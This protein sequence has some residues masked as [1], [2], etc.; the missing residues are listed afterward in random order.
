MTFKYKNPFNE[1]VSDK[2]T[3]SM[4]LKP[5]KNS[6]RLDNCICIKY[7]ELPTPVSLIALSYIR[8]NRNN[9]LIDKTKF[10]LNISRFLTILSITI[11]NHIIF[12]FQ[13]VIF[14]NVLCCEM[15]YFKTDSVVFI[16]RPNNIHRELFW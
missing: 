9:L 7:H 3:I 13:F 8:N 5:A 10:H 16:C 15:Y 12:Y 6:T 14:E 11:T 4:F 2:L 1:S